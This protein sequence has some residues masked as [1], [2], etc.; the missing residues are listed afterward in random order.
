[1]ATVRSSNIDLF[2]ASQLELPEPPPEF[3]PEQ[4]V[5]G[6]KSS[7]IQGGFALRTLKVV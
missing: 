3:S 2:G 7:L 6:N 1:M 4:N 5:R